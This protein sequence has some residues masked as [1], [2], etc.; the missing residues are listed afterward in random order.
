MTMDHPDKR[1][2]KPSEKTVKELVVDYLPTGFVAAAVGAGVWLGFQ[3]LDTVP[4]YPSKE[5][6]P[7]VADALKA[8]SIKTVIAALLA[9]FTFPAAMGLV[10]LVK[11]IQEFCFPDADDIR[12]H[13]EDVKNHSAEAQAKF[14]AGQ[15]IRSGL[16]ALAC[17]IFGGFILLTDVVNA[18]AFTKVCKDCGSIKVSRVGKRIVCR[19]P[20]CAEVAAGRKRRIYYPHKIP[21][22]HWRDPVAM[23]M[24]GYSG[25]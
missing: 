4:L 16:Y 14:R 24:D 23:S 17:A 9:V 2:K 13:A 8:S 12:D 19:E 3:Y 1:E 6:M 11:F 22:Q 15:C 18:M 7:T 5:D 20:D 21:N 10:K 25:R